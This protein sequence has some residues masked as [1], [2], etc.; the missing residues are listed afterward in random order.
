[1]SRIQPVDRQHPP[2]SID[3]AF[4]EHVANYGGRITN[5]KA[6]MGHS[7][8]TFS[9]YMQWYPLYE[10]VK[11]ILGERLAYLFAFSVSEGSN[12]PLCT[13]FFRRIII[14][15]GE[16]P[17]ALQLTDWERTVLDFGSSMAREQGRIPSDLYAAVSGR[18]SDEQVVLLV[19]FAG[20]MIATNVFNN[21]LEVEIDEYLA[22]YVPLTP[23]TPHED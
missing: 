12:C 19:A 11:D 23:A 6:T 13:T 21:A 8:L 18:F 14:D 1:M 5:M 2:A 4:R 15:H 17:E 22:P 16:R 20:Q 7:P 9:V 10:R 3:Q